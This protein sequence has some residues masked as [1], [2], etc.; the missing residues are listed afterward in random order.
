[1][2][3][4][5]DT[6]EAMKVALQ[7]GYSDV[8]LVILSGGEPLIRKDIFD[9]IKILRKY[10]KCVIIVT[11]GLLLETFCDE[12]ISLGIEQLLISV[13]SHLPEVHDRFR[14]RKGAFE[15]VMK[16]IEAVKRKRI[17]KRPFIVVRAVIAK[18]NFEQIGDYIDFFKDKVDAITFQPLQIFSN[19]LI[20]NIKQPSFLKEEDAP[21]LRDIIQT[22]SKNILFLN[23]PTINLCPIL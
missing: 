15:K 7:I 6:K 20:G 11:N 10:N 3:D 18:E 5:L 19:S 13:D 8:C 21:K 1:M 14:N 16:G 17:G 2:E 22:L 23:P 12:I 9:I 4:D